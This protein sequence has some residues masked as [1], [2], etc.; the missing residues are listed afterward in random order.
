[1]LLIFFWLYTIKRF[2]SPVLPVPLR[3][4][5]KVEAW[6]RNLDSPFAT[7]EKPAEN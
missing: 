7:K 1:V 2:F 6:Q 5:Y 4:F 3:D